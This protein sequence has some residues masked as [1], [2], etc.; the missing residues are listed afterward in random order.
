MPQLDVITLSIQI[1]VIFFVSYNIYFLIIY[2]IMPQYLALNKS[3]FIFWKTLTRLVMLFKFSMFLSCIQLF[4][5]GSRLSKFHK[6][7]SKKIKGLGKCMISNFLRFVLKKRKFARLFIV[8][9]IFSFLKT[10]LSL[11]ESNST[12]KSDFSKT[13]GWNSLLLRRYNKTIFKRKLPREYLLIKETMEIRFLDDQVLLHNLVEY[14]KSGKT[15]ASIFE[16]KVKTWD[17]VCKKKIKS[18][19]K[20]YLYEDPETYIEFLKNV[21]NVIKIPKATTKAPLKDENSKE[22]KQDEKIKKDKKN[23]NKKHEK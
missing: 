21:H 9:Q 1:S 7:F 14:P 20:L 4:L 3:Q 5:L 12:N 15:L 17:S 6:A 10:N 13:E 11:M 23:K 19:K 2:I 8:L 16:K 22:E 18:R